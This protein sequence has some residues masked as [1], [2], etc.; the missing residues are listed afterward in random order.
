MT[1]VA[2]EGGKEY[3]AEALMKKVQEMYEVMPQGW[4]KNKSGNGAP[5]VHEDG[6]E[7]W[8][9][10]GRDEINKY[11]QDITGGATEVK[12]DQKTLVKRYRMML[13]SGV[14]VAAV[15]QR[16][17]LEGVDP[18]IIPSLLVDSQEKEK[19]KRPHREGATKKFRMMLKA[20][21]PLKAVKQAAD[22]QG[23]DISDIL[24]ACGAEGEALK[25]TAKRERPV[26]MKKFRM[27][28]KSGVNPAAV[29]QAVTPYD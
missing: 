17:K 19:P 20:G 5:F 15:E 7:S 6:R 13:S 14:P 27:M 25:K 29:K 8:K 12:E 21:I 2:N 28:L 11:I 22:L 10:P 23:V 26:N 9:H 3:D 4:T 16:A 1:G 24:N 18:A